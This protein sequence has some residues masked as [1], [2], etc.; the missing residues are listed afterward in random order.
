MRRQPPPP[1]RARRERRRCGD[2]QRHFTDHPHNRQRDR[3]AR[4]GGVADRGERAGMKEYTSN[5]EIDSA[6]EADMRATVARG[7]DAAIEAAKVR[8]LVAYEK[9]LDS[10]DDD[11]TLNDYIVQET[12]AIDRPALVDRA[13]KAK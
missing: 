13:L 7:V 11:L 8:T 10:L 3:A 6:I 5:T 12:Q 4:R 9:W 2:D 1:A